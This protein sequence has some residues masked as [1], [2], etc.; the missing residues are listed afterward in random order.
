MKPSK[1]HI[2]PDF[3]LSA[4]GWIWPVWL[5][6]LIT[7]SVFLFLWLHNSYSQAQAGAQYRKL[8]APAGC[9]VSSTQTQAS[10]FNSGFEK[11]THFNCDRS[12]DARLRQAVAQS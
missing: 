12:P 3:S 8:P 6:L 11:T 2:N 7:P 5:I 1:H 9:V 10:G 4:F